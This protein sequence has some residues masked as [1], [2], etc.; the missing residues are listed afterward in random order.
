MGAAP[1]SRRD[2]LSDLLSRLVV[3]VLFVALSVN[4]LNDFLETHRVTGLLLLVSESLVVV[5]TV[6]RRRAQVVDRTVLAAFVTAV[7]LVGP[8]MMRTGT[9]AAW[10]PDVATAILSTVGLCLVIAGKLTLGRSFGLVPANRGVVAQGPYG[11]MRHPIYTG[12]LVTHVGFIAA[13]PTVWNISLILVSDAALV[14]R[15]LLEER[16][17]GQDEQYRA[18]CARVT[19]HLLPGVF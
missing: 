17:L 1:N 8:P 13:H 12:Y 5:F 15:A 3:G 10:L 16:V 2:R 6:F 4:L 9:S 7:S 14:I 19:W 11:F 18:Y